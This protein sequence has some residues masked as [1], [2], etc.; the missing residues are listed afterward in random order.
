MNYGRPDPTC[1]ARGWSGAY[2]SK[3]QQ[4]L[5]F[6]L[7][8]YLCTMSSHH[9]RKCKRGLNSRFGEKHRFA[10][11]FWLQITFTVNGNPH[12]RP[13]ESVDRFQ[14]STRKFMP[15][16]SG[17]TAEPQALLFCDVFRQEQTLFRFLSKTA[18][19][20]WR[21]SRLKRP[22]LD[23]KIIK[24]SDDRSSV[25]QVSQRGSDQSSMIRKY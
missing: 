10:P 24:I 11:P 2:F 21:K 7:P 17:M 20:L 9:S 16:P 23:V 15:E 6:K 12:C 3:L 18:I 13:M 8:K 4:E 1:C 22:P 5:L 25:L 19:C 14:W